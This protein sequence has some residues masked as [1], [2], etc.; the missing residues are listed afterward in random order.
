MG[1]YIPCKWKVKESW[2]S[3]PISDKTG[4]KIKKI[5]RNKEGH[6]IMIQESIQDEQITIET[7]YAPN[8]GAAQ[9]IR[10][11]LTD[12]KGEIDSN[13]IIVGDFNTPSYINGQMTKTEN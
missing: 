9:Y 11:T 3:N 12:I 5:K 13:T 2:S 7:I 1:K 4:L 6:Y 10:Q 8:I